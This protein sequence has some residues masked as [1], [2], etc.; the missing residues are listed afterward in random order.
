MRTGPAYKL[1]AETA[2]NLVT[3]YAL[4]KSIRRMARELMV[5]EKTVS[6]ALIRAGVELRGRCGFRRHL[7]TDVELSEMVKAYRAGEGTQ[8]IAD[9]LGTTAA[10]VADRL[11]RSGLSL[12]PPGFRK[13]ED[14]H[15][16]KGGRV[17][18][19]GYIQVLI[20]P[21]DPYYAMAKV[22]SSSADGGRYVFEHR[23]KMAKKL[24]RLLTE[25][26]TVHHK[27]G[28]GLNNNLKNLQ[29]RQGKHGKGASFRCCDCGSYNVK[30]QA[31]AG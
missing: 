27:D 4:G 17:A 31:L 23:Y 25:H 15:A 9:K 21:S 5:N 1:D 2:Q 7:T 12:R 28:N 6:T 11:K 24:G 3:S 20:Y 30:A 26:E 29:L 19:E 14:H 22:K 13:G 8:E 10:I 18:H 16:W